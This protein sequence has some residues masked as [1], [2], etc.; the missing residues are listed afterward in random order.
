MI[1]IEID[2]NSLLTMLVPIR[3]S[4]ASGADRGTA[5]AGNPG[6]LFE[7]RA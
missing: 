1:L 4:F 3:L 2:V 7:K 5:T 6:Q